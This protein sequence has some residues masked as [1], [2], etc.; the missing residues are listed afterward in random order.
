[1]FKTLTINN[2]RGI[3]FAQINQLQRVNLFFGKNN[4]GKSTVLEALFLITGQ[5]NPL[6]PLSVNSMRNHTRYT[7]Q[8]L[9][10]E[11]YQ[12]NPDNHIKITLSGDETRELEISFFV[13]HA[14][15]VNLRKIDAGSSD[16]QIKSYGLKL[17][18]SEGNP[19]QRFSSELIIK[20]GDSGNGKTR[21]DKRYTERIRSLYLPANYYNPTTPSQ[22]ANII[23][24]KQENEILEPLREIDPNI[25]DIQLVGSDVLVDIGAKQ[26]LPFNMMGDGLRKLLTIIVSIHQCKDGVLL[27]DE[28]DNG[29]HFSA[30]KVLWKA[31]LK[32]AVE[33][34]VQL[35]ISTHNIDSIKGLASILSDSNYQR[36]QKEVA[37]FKLLR[38][39][40]GEVIALKYDYPSF[41]YSV[42]QQQEMR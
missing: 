19:A 7:E 31:I 12:L 36:Y 26:R 27:I 23:V 20:E 22:L 39:N 40:D 9:K 1:M 42:N 30:M 5:S 21:I 18:F 28:I 29:F 17:D 38:K 32:A 35:F 11:F 16:S 2:F 6:L 8:D 41:I 10:T 15:T 3:R 24:N 4:C 37:A 33:N 34:N 13:S 14:N 25:R